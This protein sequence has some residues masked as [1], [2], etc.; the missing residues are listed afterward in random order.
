MNVK[1]GITSEKMLI[2]LQSSIFPWEKALRNL[3]INDMIFLF[4]KTFQNIISDCL[5]IIFPSR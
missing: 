2:T 5:L 3:F 4:N 1:Y